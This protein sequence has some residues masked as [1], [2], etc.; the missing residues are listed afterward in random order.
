MKST[1][2][3]PHSCGR[4][5]VMSSQ[6]NAKYLGIMFVIQKEGVLGLYSS[7]EVNKICC[8]KLICRILS[9]PTLWIRWIKQY[10]IRK[11]TFWK[12]NENSIIWMWKKLLKY[13][14]LA[15][16]FCKDGNSKW[17]HSSFWFGVWSPLKKLFD[18]R[19][20]RAVLRLKF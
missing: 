14:T 19:R 17:L 5:P 18:I 12:A 9:Q 20:P 1:V 3:T 2:S 10:L 8:L 13:R 7:S 16:S 4:G 6:K 15:K 11:R